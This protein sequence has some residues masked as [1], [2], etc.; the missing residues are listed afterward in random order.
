MKHR[1]ATLEGALLDAAV[2]LAEGLTPKMLSEAG[3]VS[4]AGMRHRHCFIQHEFGQSMCR[5]RPS[6]DWVLAGPIIDREGIT[7]VHNG[8]KLGD[9]WDAYHQAG[10]WGP[11]GQVTEPRYTGRDIATGS[12]YLEAA[13]RAYV[14]AKLGEEVELP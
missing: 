6:T 4:Y 8:A 13:M 7:V 1:T 12:T 9:Q 3:L 10:Y 11:D 5:Y 2:A 14:A